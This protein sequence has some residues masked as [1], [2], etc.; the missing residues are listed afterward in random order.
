MA[1]RPSHLGGGRFFHAITK[2]VNGMAI[3][4]VAIKIGSI[5]AGSNDLPMAKKYGNG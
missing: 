1:R 2:N 4:P 3:T 5:I